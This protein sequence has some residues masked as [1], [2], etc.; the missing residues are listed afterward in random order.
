MLSAQESGQ[1]LRR[2]SLTLWGQGGLGGLGTGGEE[3][4]GEG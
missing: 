3:A 4:P 2:R 1:G